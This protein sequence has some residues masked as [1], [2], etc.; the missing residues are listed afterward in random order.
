MISPLLA[1]LRKPLNAL[2]ESTRQM[3]RF[4]PNAAVQ[5][6]T[7]A[8]RESSTSLPNCDRWD[9]AFR[10]REYLAG[11]PVLWRRDQPLVESPV[12]DE[13]MRR[14]THPLFERLRG[15]N[16]NPEFLPKSAERQA[17]EHGTWSNCAVHR[18]LLP[19]GAGRRGLF[20]MPASSGSKASCRSGWAR[21]TLRG[22]RATGSS[23]RIRRRRR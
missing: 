11:P 10:S 12:R 17:P 9:D 5:M 15:R 2:K 21:A 22:A 7:A 20:A 23:S 8:P 18:V 6:K 3:A 1:P 14:D 13:R 16:A 19:R 4:I